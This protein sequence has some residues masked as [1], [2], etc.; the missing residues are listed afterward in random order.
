M[1]IQLSVSIVLS[2]LIAEEGVRAPSYELDE[3]LVEASLIPSSDKEFKQG[4]ETRFAREDIANSTATSVLDFLQDEAGL[5]FNSIYGNSRS[6]APVWRGFAGARRTLLLVDG[7]PRNRPD[8]ATMDW[9][10][11]SLPAIESLSLR[12][13]GGT[14]RYGSGALGG[15][16]AIQSREP[17]DEAE[18]KLSGASGND[19]ARSAQLALSLPGE[20]LSLTV[21][22]ESDETNGFREH[23]FRTDQS[24][25]VGLATS[26]EGWASSSLSFLA[27]ESEFANPGG[28]SYE[29]FRDTPRANA[30]YV[31]GFEELYQ[32]EISRRELG[33]TL[34]LRPGHADWNHQL[35]ARAMREE[36]LI[37]QGGFYADNSLNT[38]QGELVSKFQG[39]KLRLEAG[40]RWKVEALDFT[41]YADIERTSP[42]QEAELSRSTGGLFVIAERALGE[43]WLVRQGLGVEGYLLKGDSAGD[44]EASSFSESDERLNWATESAL[45][46]NDGEDLRAWLRYEQVYRAPLLDEIAGYQGY[47]LQVPF[48]AGLRPEEGHRFE[49]GG[50]FGRE[51]LRLGGLIYGTWLED[52]IA[53]HD[54]LNRNLSA[55]RRVGADLWFGYEEEHWSLNARYG[56]VE[57]ELLDGPFSGGELPLVPTHTL[58]G[59]VEVK[60]IEELTLATNV[61]YQTEA[62]QG[63]DFENTLTRVPARVLVGVSARWKFSENCTIRASISNLLDENYASYAAAGQFYPGAGRQWLVGASYEF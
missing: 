35:V 57:A 31:N 11:L 6:G 39:A 14:V 15:V 3:T 18:L 34:R 38:F 21:N 58:S 22:A 16:I 33:Y 10:S 13:G 32:S 17:D 1:S 12:P 27:A 7:L 54:E 56:W 48:N 53:F 26:S 61:S 23:G 42:L 49:L 62:W 47:L 20:E 45:E 40:L 4:G 43:R 37:D 59:G 9:G 36:R 28:L 24:I 8:L 2:C 63:D 60:P 25:R 44:S 29:Q 46:F 30:G 55:T 52:E 51:S 41:S 19:G 50:E 5:P